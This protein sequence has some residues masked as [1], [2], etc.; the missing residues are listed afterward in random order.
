MSTSTP[1]TTESAPIP[2][3]SPLGAPRG[4]EPRSSL[5]VATL[6]AVFWSIVPGLAGLALLGWIGPVGDW[7]RAQGDA[8]AVLFV[9]A[10]ALTSGL[11]LLPTYAQSFLGGWIFGLAVGF[12]L[13]LGGFAGG[14]VLGFLVSRVVTGDAL[15]RRIAAHPQASV[16]KEALVGSGFLRT[17]ST[18]TLLR[19]PPNSPFALMNLVLSGGGAGFNPYMLGTITGMI[20]R[21]AVVVAFAAA[22][23]AGGSRDIQGL[24]KETPWWQ[25]IGGIAAMIAVLLILT[26]IGKRA[27]RKAGLS[28]PK[29]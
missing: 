29:R 18:V 5:R 26:A 2:E 3:E 25:S 16:V 21:T 9:I 12:T 10:F 17:V 14:A 24:L 15:E 8:G 13:A 6:L 27:L 7:L 20:P 1:P 23:A 4:V 22:G 28:A 19:L 11:G